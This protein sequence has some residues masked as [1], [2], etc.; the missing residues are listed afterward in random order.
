MSDNSTI[1]IVDD[2]PHA[3]DT[4]EMV[5]FSEDYTLV[6]AESG[7]E[8]VQKAH[9]TLPDLILLDIMMPGMNGFEVCKTL[10]QDPL[11]AKVPIMM[12]TA[13]DDRDSR[14]RGIEVGADDFISKPFD[15]IEL[16]A[17]VRT[18]TQLNRYRRL[19][20][21]RMRLEWVIERSEHGYVILNQQQHI[22]YANPQACLYLGLVTPAD[23]PEQTFLTLAQ[24]HYQCSPKEAWRDWP[25]PN[26]TVTRYLVRPESALT[27][28]FWLQVDIF[29]PPD[30]IETGWVVQLKDVTTAMALQRDMR[31]FHGFISHKLNTP[32]AAIIG[33]LQLLQGYSS[34]YSPEEIEELIYIASEHAERLHKDFGEIQQYLDLS[35]FASPGLGFPVADLPTLAGKIA[36][37]LEIETFTTAIA[38]DGQTAELVLS[39]I[40]IEL[41]LW[42][43]LDNA[44]KF[45]PE[46]N[47][48]VELLASRQASHMLKLQIRDNGQHLPPEQLT[49]AWEPYYQ[50]EK[51]F[52]GEVPGMGLGL[53]MVATLIWG[54]GG[55]CQIHNRQDQP[56]IIVELH[57]PLQEAAY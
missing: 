7:A 28:A 17:R 31:E 52:T 12:I 25:A 13:L 41:I 54:V 53:S 21:E 29:D 56:G 15:R 30:R 39:P 10:R 36:S 47:P 38:E 16:R 40:T 18:V 3:R 51:Y 49:Q 6:F 34:K 24:E 45:H 4:L 48:A 9:T 5:L 27:K 42:E 1:L 57:I 22:V 14:I 8:A 46:K 19:L 43:I 35:R 50:G 37:A 33:S 20:S 44:K 32:L 55:T 23:I 2:D 11:L 26:D